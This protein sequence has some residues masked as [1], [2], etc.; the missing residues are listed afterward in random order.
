MTKLQKFGLFME[1]GGILMLSGMAMKAECERHKAAVKLLDTEILK[2]TLE[3]QNIL[4]KAKIRRLEK[5]LA[6]LK[7]EKEEEA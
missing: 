2:C 3:I 4:D 7:G 6:E 1:I 5:E